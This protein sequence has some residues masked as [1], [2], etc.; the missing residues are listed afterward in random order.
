MFGTVGELS[1]FSISKSGS[2]DVV[3]RGTVALDTALTATGNSA[4]Y[5]VGAVASGEN[6]MLLY[7]VIALV[8][9]QHQQLLLNYNQMIIQV[10]Q[11][12]QIVQPLQL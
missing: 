9:H 11:V 7:I 3:V 6:V 2:S 8:V 4:A 5:Q 12:Q 10:L 1:P